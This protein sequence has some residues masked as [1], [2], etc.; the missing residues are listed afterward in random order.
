MILLAHEEQNRLAPRRLMWLMLPESTAN[1][2][3]IIIICKNKPVIKKWIEIT[4]IFL[5]QHRGHKFNFALSH[6]QKEGRNQAVTSSIPP[7]HIN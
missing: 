7:D 3:F 2:C 1:I 4:V 6:S 5:A